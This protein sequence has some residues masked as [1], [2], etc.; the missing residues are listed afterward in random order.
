M[1]ANRAVYEGLRQGLC[2]SPSA[3]PRF[4]CRA[5][6]APFVPARLSPLTTTTTTTTTPPRV[7]PR[8]YCYSYSR[9]YGTSASGATVAPDGTMATGPGSAYVSHQRLLLGTTPPDKDTLRR[10]PT[11]AIEYALRL[12]RNTST[13]APGAEERFDMRGRIVQ[14]V[15]F[16]IVDRRH[17][18]TPFL[19][20]CLMDAMADPLGSSK[21]IQDLITEMFSNGMVPT[22]AICRSAL[23]ALMVHPDYLVQLRILQTMAEYWY[24]RDPGTQQAL[25]VGMLRDEQYELAY[26]RFMEAVEGGVPLEAWVYD[27]FIVV[28][29]KMRFLDEMLAIL[30]QRRLLEDGDDTHVNLLYFAL[31]VCSQNFHYDGTLFAWSTAVNNPLVQPPDGV[32]ENILSTAAR[33]GDGQLASWALDY[34]SQHMRLQPGHYE[35]MAEALCHCRDITATLRTLVVMAK[36]GILVER[37]STRPLR[38]MLMREPELIPEAV[39]ALEELHLADHIPLAAVCAVLEAIACTEGSDKAMGVYESVERYCGVR[40]DSFMIQQLLLNSQDGKLHKLLLEDYANNVTTDFVLQCDMIRNPKLVLRSLEAGRVDMAL[41]FANLV[42]MTFHD[43][44]PQQ[45]VTW[46]RPLVSECIERQE[47]G[48]FAVLDMLNEVGNEKTKATVSEILEEM[49]L[50]KNGHAEQGW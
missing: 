1:T 12:L 36:N 5:I 19:Y 8:N 44:Q 28:F 37:A 40:P 21:V 30:W 23:N 24:Q 25:L 17:P 13:W 43:K 39:A 33:H 9:R 41:R 38:E 10:T 27:I 42:R 11:D 20:E 14:L 15:G 32:V 18:K 49:R 29:G 35:A 34:L 2:Q 3:S 47:R 45:P 48:I 26:T 50:A 22:E 46:V 4:F 16:L 7:S 6:R 31:D